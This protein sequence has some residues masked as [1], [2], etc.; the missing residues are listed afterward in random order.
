MKNIMM[1]SLPLFYGKSFEDPDAFLFEFG[2]LCHS[3]NYYEDA[4]KLKLFPTTLKDTTLRWFISL[5]QHT[6]YTQDDMR[7]T[8]L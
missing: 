1:E 3:Y 6:I 7:S 2:I 8:F 4:H 5:G